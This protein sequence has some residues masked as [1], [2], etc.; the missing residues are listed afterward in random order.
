[1]STADSPL[2]WLAKVTAKIEPHEL[3]AVV[4][5]FFYFFFLLGSYFILRPVRDAMGTV[6]SETE[7]A[8]LWTG[9]FFG[10]FAAALVYAFAASKL[11]LSTLLP[12]VYGVIA[13][14][15]VGFYA[16]FLS[17]RSPGP[18]LG[19]STSGSRCSTC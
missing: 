1:M 8:T 13:L 7:L 19:P 12:W 15:M 9:T 11:K 5:A 18:W 4:L 14:S 17:T 6:F 10:S 3:K 2:S 16:L